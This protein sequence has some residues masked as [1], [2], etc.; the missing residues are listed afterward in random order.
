MLD[1]LQYLHH[2]KHVLIKIL[3]NTLYPSVFAQTVPEI[4]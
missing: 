2:D 1:L 4:P 3:K